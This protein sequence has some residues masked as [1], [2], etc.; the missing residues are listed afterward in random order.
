MEETD[1]R[2]SELE[3]RIRD[4]FS[5]KFIFDSSTSLLRLSTFFHL[6]QEYS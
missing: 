1:K 5:P 2:I 3:D 6:F 4:I